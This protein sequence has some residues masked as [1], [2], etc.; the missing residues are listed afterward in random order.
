MTTLS[1]SWGV[2]TLRLPRD[3]LTRLAGFLRGR[4][5]VLETITDT[6]PPVVV[7]SPGVSDT[8]RERIPGLVAEFGE[9]EWINVLSG[10]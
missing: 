6:T 3:V 9:L 8:D 7:L 1:T 4:G 5:I 2:Q 10:S